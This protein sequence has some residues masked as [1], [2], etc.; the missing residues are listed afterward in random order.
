MSYELL[1]YFIPLYFLALVSVC[2]LWRWFA[3]YQKTGK[4][5]I[6]FHDTES[7][8]GYLARI[9]MYF[10][11]VGAFVI[12]LFSLHPSQYQRL[13]PFELPEIA[14]FFGM[15][16]LL[17]S[18]V[19]MGI[20][21]SQMGA[22]FRI[23]IDNRQKTAL[24]HKGLYKFTRN[25]IY[26]GMELALIGFFLSIPNIV[27]LVMLVLGHFTL[28]VEIRLEEAHLLALHGDEF[29]AYCKRVRRWV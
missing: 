3:F 22:S 17:I 23:G 27:S 4:S 21:R 13:K 14:Q 12:F 19:V 24:V 16:F 8:H 15:T 28:Q 26:L 25:P 29:R 7:A 11:F 5:P 20:A 10:V 18:L 1:R 6:I 2:F 9:L